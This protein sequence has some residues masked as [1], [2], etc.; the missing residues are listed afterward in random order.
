MRRTLKEFRTILSN[1]A[2]HQNDIRQAEEWLEQA[3]DL[4]REGPEAARR[5]SGE[6]TA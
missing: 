5:V 3:A 6:E 2:V 4:A 1:I